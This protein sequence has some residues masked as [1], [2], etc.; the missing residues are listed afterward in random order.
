[1]DLRSFW[2]SRRRHSNCH[3]AGVRLS[4]NYI[5]FVCLLTIAWQLAFPLLGIVA[6]CCQEDQ[7]HHSGSSQVAECP[8]HGKS[9]PA[10]DSMAMEHDTEHQCDCATIQCSSGGVV[11]AV[12]GPAAVLPSI[13]DMHPSL[14][15]SA[16][17]RALSPSTT[18]LA[19]L[20][21]AP[22]PRA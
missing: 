21:L 17:P 5:P 14:E 13:A 16:L 15:A 8:I 3:G 2:P 1:M 12:F 11:I 20:P 4:R 10:M 19:P 22:P 18:P 7:P 9:A 6:L